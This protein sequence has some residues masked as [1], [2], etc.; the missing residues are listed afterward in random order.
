MAKVLFSRGMLRD[1]TFAETLL[2]IYVEGESSDRQ[3]EIVTVNVSR[4]Q[5]RTSLAEVIATPGKDRCFIP[6][7]P[8]L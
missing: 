4:V 3:L 1:P 6:G 7:V 2:S 8:F 5:R